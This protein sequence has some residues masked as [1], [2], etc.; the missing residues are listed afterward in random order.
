[1]Q[2]REKKTANVFRCIDNCIGIANG[3]FSLLRPE[4]S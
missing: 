1:M 4:Y 2:Q 3:K